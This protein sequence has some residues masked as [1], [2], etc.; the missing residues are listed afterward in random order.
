MDCRT[1]RI[2]LFRKL[3]G[4]LSSLESEKLDAHLLSCEFCAR[5]MKILLVPQRIS[6]AIP[7]PEPSPFFYSRVKA[8]IASKSRS[9]T[10]WQ[11]ILGISR[12]VVPAFGAITLALLLTLAYIQVRQPTPDLYQVFDSLFTTSDRTNRMVITEG[13]ITDESVLLA[14]A[15][16]EPRPV[17]SPATSGGK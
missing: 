2:W 11:M 10:L 9:T 17:F 4:E 16:Q 3:D 8:R 15:D 5:E 6:Q 7:A 12:Q 14:I 13:E 1:V